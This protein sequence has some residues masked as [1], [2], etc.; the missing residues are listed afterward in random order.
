LPEAKSRQRMLF[1]LEMYDVAFAYTPS[2][3]PL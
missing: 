2:L 3:S 1:G